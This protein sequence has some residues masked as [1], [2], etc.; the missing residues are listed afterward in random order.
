[1]VDQVQKSKS[2]NSERYSIP[3]SFKKSEQAKISSQK[4]SAIGGI[5]DKY[6]DRK[7]SIKQSQRQSSRYDEVDEDE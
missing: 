2:K 1:M 3:E 4:Q 6:S 5:S 7:S